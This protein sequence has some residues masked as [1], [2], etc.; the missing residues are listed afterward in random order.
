[1]LVQKGYTISKRSCYIHV[2]YSHEFS[3]ASPEGS[4][5]PILGFGTL[6]EFMNPVQLL[7]ECKTGKEAPGPSGMSRDID[8]FAEVRN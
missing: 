7:Y 8:N 4:P 5:E 2:Y 6:L 1:M 3:P